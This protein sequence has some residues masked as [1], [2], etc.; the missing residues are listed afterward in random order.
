MGGKAKG[1]LADGSPK[2]HKY[3]VLITTTGE[4]HSST[5]YARRPAGPR[6]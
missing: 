3:D 6:A 1:K 2:A 4:Y 5:P